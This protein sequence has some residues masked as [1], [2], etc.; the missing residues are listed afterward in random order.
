[1]YLHSSK[2]IRQTLKN[3]AV[4][5]RDERPSHTGQET[6][7][8]HRCV[9]LNQLPSGCCCKELYGAAQK[10]SLHERCW[11]VSKHLLTTCQAVVTC[12]S[13]HNEFFGAA[14]DF[15][16]QR[17]EPPATS[18][19]LSRGMQRS[20]WATGGCQRVAD[21]FVGLFASGL[22]AVE[23]HNQPRKALALLGNNS[24]YL[25]KSYRGLTMFLS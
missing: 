6:A 4:N 1:M 2:V 18:Y 10:H 16:W 23:L 11:L 3:L 24:P 17:Q 21:W 5:T 13:N 12:K 19:Q 9:F 15:T 7:H 22:K 25:W 14:T 8:W 20:L